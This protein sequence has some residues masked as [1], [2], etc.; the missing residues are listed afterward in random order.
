MIPAAF[1]YLR[2]ATLDEAVATLAAQGE[3]AKL[4]AGGHSLLPMMRLRLARPATLVDLGALRGE[5]SYVRDEGA[6]VAVGALTRHHDVATSDVLYRR[7]PLVTRAAAL[8]GD[9]QVRHRGTLGGSLAHAD[10]AADMPAVALALDAT[11]V[12]RGPASER[13]IPARDFFR[14]FFETA[15]QPDELLREVR[16]A[17]PRAGHGWAYLKFNRRAQDWATVGVAA[18]VECDGGMVTRAAVALANMGATPLRADAVEQALVGR[19]AGD[20]DAVEAAAQRA[21][22]G[23]SPASDLAASADYR[24]HLARVLTRRALQQ[25]LQLAG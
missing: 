10:P 4:L 12:V 5:L 16:F 13:E 22:E 18:V 24:R 8:V 7:V 19:D 21:D 3:E 14:G 20:A 11:M 25:A 6:T 23:T 17:V 9:P 15:L 1:E 2:P